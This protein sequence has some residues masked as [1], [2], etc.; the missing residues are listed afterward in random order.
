[1]LENARRQFFL[2][3]FAILLGVASI[4][5]LQPSLGNDLKGGTQLLYDVPADVLDELVKKERAS[6][7]SVMAQTISVMRERIDPNGT[8]DPLITRSGETGI[9]VELSYFED[10]QDLKRVLDRISNLGRLEMRMVA[11]DGWAK[12]GDALQAARLKTEKD[13]LAAWI[14]QPDNAALIQKDPRN[15]RRYNEDQANGPL[16]KFL[17]WYPREIR[18]NPKDATRWDLSYADIP[19]FEPITVQAFDEAQWN[20]GAIPEETLALDN[21]QHRLVEF[22]AINMAERSFSGEDLDP[23]G[24]GLGQGQNG[25]PAVNYELVGALKGAY[26]DWSAEHKGKASAI[27]LN[28]YIKSAPTFRNKIPGRGIIEGDF[29]VDEVEELVKVLR[30]GSLRIEPEKLSQTTIGPNLGEAAITRGLWSIVGG[31]ALVFAFMLAFYKIAG[32]IAC[33]ALLLNVFLLYAGILFMQATI[34]LPGLGGIVLT[35]GMA[36]D[37]NVLIYERIRE[38]LQKGKEMLQAV[39]SGFERAMSAILDS[40]ITTFLV[41]LV[42]F[43]VGVGPVRGFAVTLMVGI[44]TTVFTQFF[45]SR[46]L[47]HWAL[48]SNKLDGWQPNTLFENRSVDFVGKIKACVVLSALVILGG[49]GYSLN[50][51]PEEKLSIDFTGGSNLQMV[52]AEATDAPSIRAKLEGDAEFLAAYPTYSVNGFGEDG[53]GYNIRLK[54]T[55]AQREE[56]EGQRAAKREER[57][58]YLAKLSDENL[59]EAER[60]ALRPPEA[61]TPPYVKELERVFGDQLVEPAFSGPLMVEQPGQNTSLMLAQIDV[62]FARPV[63]TAQVRERLGKGLAG[64]EVTP[65][66]NAAAETGKDFRVEWS[67]QSS[68]REWQLAEIIS[69]ELSGMEDAD[70]NQIVLSDPF[71]EAQEIQGRLV[72]DLRNAAIGALILAWALIVFYLR[73]RFH[74]YKYGLAAVVALIHDVLVT[75]GVVVLFNHMGWV[76]AEISLAMIA[77]FLTI[78]GYSVNDTIVVFD[79]IRE[80]RIEN[81]RNNVDESFRS[82]INR[83]LN[84]TLSRTVLTTVLTLFVV[85]A[86]LIVNWDSGSDLEAFA[87]AMTIGMCCGVYSTMYIAAP[88]LIWMDRGD[89]VEVPEG[90]RDPERE[91]DY[92]NEAELA[93][94]EAAAAHK[95]A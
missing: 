13:R 28:G 8:L 87:F 55:S 4:A 69:E 94:Q 58:A 27:I 19:D 89:P 39:R 85:I 62:H 38:E 42:L 93:A 15:I 57:K 9:L 26:A 70:G 10:P 5:F 88:I 32:A 44:V 23:S 3:L 24:V 31:G 84:Q 68:T 43:N 67:T 14:K 63:L 74:E 65:L 51:P 46:L 22:M 49:V 47:F 20:G 45:V 50:V 86:Q 25:L 59:S 30:T 76:N 21:K 7:D 53:T 2:V 41:G 66:G 75:F 56:I 95:E 33:V 90:P 92:D 60:E 17:N 91:G 61:F 40:N 37:A 52:C 79:R 71:P 35:L 1:M 54:L 12:D 81:A 82:L 11:Y 34:T 18:P 77:C 73:I 36:V 83:S 6:K 72:N 29:T 80:N 78:I 16:L 48:S 64:G